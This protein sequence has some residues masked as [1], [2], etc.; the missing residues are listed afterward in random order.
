MYRSDC[1]VSPCRLGHSTP[2]PSYRVPVGKQPTLRLNDGPPCI[3]VQNATE[4]AL[5]GVKFHLV[6]DDAHQFV[7]CKPQHHPCDDLHGRGARSP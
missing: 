6:S 4:R 2:A 7:R 5:S 3:R 1:I